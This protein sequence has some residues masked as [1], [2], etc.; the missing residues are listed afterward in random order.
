MA[1][2]IKFNPKV[3]S[4]LAESKRVVE[5]TRELF[6]VINNQA[7]SL[8]RIKIIQLLENI[9]EIFSERIQHIKELEWKTRQLIKK[10]DIAESYFELRDIHGELNDLQKDFFIAVPSVAEIHSVCTDYRDRITK[11]IITMVIKE[12]ISDSI[13]L[14]DESFAY[15][16]VGSDGR[17]E[18][19]LLTDQDNLIVY[20][21]S[22]SRYKEFYHERF[23]NLLVERLALC[24]F[25]KCT[26]EIMP[27]NPK[28]RGSLKAWA[29]RVDYL[30]R[31]SDPDFKKNLV[32]LI[33]LTDLRLV[34]GDEE[35]GQKF[36][37]NTYNAIFNNH[38]VLSEIAK[39]AA[40][41]GLA[42]GFMKT[43][44]TEKKG[45]FKGY[46]N[47]K[48][49]AWAPFVLIIRAFA[50]KNKVIKT[51]TIERIDELVRLGAFSN[52]AGAKLKNSFYL[53]SRF[54]IYTQVMYLIGKYESDI[55]LNPEDLTDSEKDQL[56]DTL[57]QIESLQNLLV[58]SMGL[59][60]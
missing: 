46:I 26:G 13:Y 27:S 35:L 6:N 31:F 59:R 10:I 49:H 41:L 58:E 19:T 1:I 14:P 33:V 39:S 20:E 15:F 55:Y 17:K 2:D 32:N 45:K 48:L 53:L 38:I 51:G 37:K 24:G 23:S 50:M 8:D 36:V 7:Q 34:F 9:S 22:P 21:D 40:S 52:E 18:Q 16:A 42:K 43:L 4:E 5:V 56:I 44:R 11:K 28:W 57:S 3:L 29:E 12:L 25:K 30:C 47:L 60:I 54:K